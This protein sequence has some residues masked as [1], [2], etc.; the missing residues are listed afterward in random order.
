MRSRVS[1]QRQAMDSER[2]SLSTLP[3]RGVKLNLGNLIARYFV[4]R[5]LVSL[6]YFLKYRCMVHP[7]AHV[8]LS[9]R[10]RFGQGTTIRQYAIINTSGGLVTFG[11]G[12]ELGP[13]SM[14]VTKSKDVQIGDYVRIGPHVSMTA[15]N[16]NYQH[17]GTLI[18]DQGIREEGI[19]IDSDVWIGAG[20]V[21]TDGVHI[22]E[23]AVVASGAVVAKDVAPY[24]IVGGVPAK[25]IGSRS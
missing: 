19:V 6:I 15:S 10:I 20:A 14:I 3:S 13:F 12:C 23:G 22:G 25:P 11:K 4:P 2:R 16:R 7:K 8:Q 24:S 5:P 9:S 21:I 1:S 18:V 17:R